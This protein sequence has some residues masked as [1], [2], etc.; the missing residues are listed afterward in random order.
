MARARLKTKNRGG[1]TG[2]YRCSGCSEPIVPGERYWEWSFRYGGT[3]RQH[4][5]HGMPRPSQLTQSNM[6][7]VY[8]GIESVEDL[9]ARDDW[10]TEDA[11][12]AVEELRST[13]EEVAQGY[14]DAAEPFGDAGPHAERA[15]ELDSYADQLDGIDLSEWEHVENPDAL[16]EAWREDARSAV[17]DAIG[18]AP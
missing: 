14:R 11:V 18:S 16:G 2:E 10:S 12:S 13:V 9:I 3:Y 8:A 1:K 6:S 7:E 5:T 17:E 15:D 4:A